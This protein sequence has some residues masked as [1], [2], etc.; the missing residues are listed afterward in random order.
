MWILQDKITENCITAK[1]KCILRNV[2][3]I[4]LYEYSKCD[5]ELNYSITK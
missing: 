1:F 2:G 4:L 3:D 5:Q